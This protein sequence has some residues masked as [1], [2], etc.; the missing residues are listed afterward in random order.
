MR[1]PTRQ[2]G[3]AVFDDAW[4]VGALVGCLGLA[5][6]VGL[7]DSKGRLAV[8][9]GAVSAINRFVFQ[10]TPPE[11]KLAEIA[12]ARCEGIVAGHSGLPFTQVIGD[13]LWHNAGVVGLPANDGTTRVWYSVL[14]PHGDEIHVEH[15]WIVYDH[16]R[17]A[18]KMRRRGLPE[19]Y[20][21]ALESGL[22]DNCEI[23]PPAETASRGEAITLAPVRWRPLQRERAAS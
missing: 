14:S 7:Y 11:D 10:S 3:S 12:A 6:I 2:S 5:V 8:V 4:L 15:R 1:K 13:R 20:A 22:W 9:H 21:S 23:L 19:E 18:A 16:R 17:A